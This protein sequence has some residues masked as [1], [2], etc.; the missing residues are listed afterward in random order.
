MNT[1]KQDHKNIYEA[2]AAF[3]GD[4]RPLP[5][6][7]EVDYKTKN[8]KRIH[9]K[10]TKLGK[11]RE[12]VDPIL[13]K[14]G[15]AAYHVLTKEKGQDAVEAVL[16]H[17][18]YEEKKETERI[19]QKEQTE[20]EEVNNVTERPIYH[21]KNK[22]TSGKIKISVDEDD[23]MKGKAEAITYAKRYTLAMVL[24]IASDDDNDAPKK[25]KKH[26]KISKIIESIQ[27]KQN[28]EDVNKLLNYVKNNDKYSKEEKEKAEQFAER[29][30]AALEDYGETDEEIKKEAA[31]R[32][33][34]DDYTKE[35]LQNMARENELKSSG[36][37]EEIAE[38]LNELE[39]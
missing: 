1:T 16:V 35:E 30:L 36:T 28:P 26:Y 12:V 37:K 38:R 21:E 13:G 17:E 11:M 14:H 3:H 31:E 9:Y 39:K 2:L 5:R 27:A 7:G 19:E 18:S 29:R 10:Y 34:A 24:G 20:M 33:I 23:G 8:G 25:R 15:L 4:M 22:I 6:N 32:I